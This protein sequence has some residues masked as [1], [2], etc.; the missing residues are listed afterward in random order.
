[1]ALGTVTGTEAWT[2]PCR[3]RKP[4]GRGEKSDLGL[5]VLV[6]L[7]ASAGHLRCIFLGKIY[8]LVHVGV[9]KDK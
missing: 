7:L 2:E 5:E 3:R 4:A 6:A 1:M 9:L 8:A